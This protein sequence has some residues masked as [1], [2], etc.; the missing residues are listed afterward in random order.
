MR[1]KLVL[2]VSWWLYLRDYFS[3]ET[4]LLTLAVNIYSANTADSFTVYLRSQRI[5]LELR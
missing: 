2:V 3:A 5:H 1:D 4:G